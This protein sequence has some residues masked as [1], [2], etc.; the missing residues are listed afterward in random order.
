M[1]RNK[2]SE[3]ASFIIGQ[4]TNGFTP[5]F[6]VLIEPT[7]LLPSR[8]KEWA[9]SVNSLG[10]IFHFDFVRIKTRFFISL[11]IISLLMPDLKK[12]IEIGLTQKDRDGATRILN[13]LLA[14]EYMLYTKTRKYHWNVVGLDFSE[15]HKFFEAQ[16]EELDDIVDGVAE[17]IRKIGGA[18]GGTL[19]EFLD[20]TRLKEN[21]GKNPESEAMIAVLL[22]DHE[23][24]VQAIRADIETVQSKYH[25]VGTADFLTGLLQKHETMAWMLRSYL[26]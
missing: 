17:R 6:P 23:R 22:A 1:S 24:I 2:I 26:Q 7:E 15:L 21:P 13:V 25:D 19:R 10:A 3:R 4:T 18:A 11:S 16:Y 5:K 20:E 8:F 12:S 9:F 14:D